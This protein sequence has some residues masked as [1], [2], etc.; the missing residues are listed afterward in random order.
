MSNTTFRTTA[1]DK[2][3]LCKFYWSNESAEF[4]TQ[5]KQSSGGVL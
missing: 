2:Y 1:D 4:N 5:K 3:Y